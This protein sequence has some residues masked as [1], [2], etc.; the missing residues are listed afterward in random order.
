M[1]KRSG[2][3]R[4]LSPSEQPADLR[5]EREAFVRTFLKKG[6]E[7]T[8]NL[9]R[10]NES[11]QQLVR[12]LDDENARL[13]SLVE[14]KRAV[15]EL[16]GAMEALRAERAALTAR[17][18]ELEMAYRQ[19][20]QQHETLQQELN[21]LASLYVASFQLGGS[22]SARR[23]LRHVCE[24]LEQLIGAQAF[25]VYV[26]EAGGKSARPVAS[27]GVEPRRLKS[28]ATLEGPIGDVCLTGVPRVLDSVSPKAGEPIAVIPLLVDGQVVGVIAVQALLPHK[29]DWALVD[30]ELFKLLCAQAGSALVGAALY[31]QRPE[32]LRALDALA[33]RVEASPKISATSARVT[34]K[35][36]RVS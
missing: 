22:L 1:S 27:R 24:L 32:P 35:K 16:L 33:E 25:V 26:V 13:K 21:D 2:R 20:K 34:K 15:A 36:A 30:H 31:A 29:R 12:K 14:S 11:L 18:D 17:S 8:E 7:L 28:V 6:I 4:T 10:E 9:L 5:A 23:V 3:V 19:Q